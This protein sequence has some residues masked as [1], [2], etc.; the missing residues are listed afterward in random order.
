MV[1]PPT[2]KTNR[3]RKKT[4]AGATTRRLNRRQT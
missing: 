1:Q 4:T 3:A 2:V